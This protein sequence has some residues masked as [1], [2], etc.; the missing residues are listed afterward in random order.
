MFEKLI[1]GWIQVSFSSCCDLPVNDKERERSPGDR[2]QHQERVE[3][4]V[5]TDP[6]PVARNEAD[7]GIAGS[8]VA[9][10]QA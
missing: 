3:T 9:N 7:G 10:T 5:L 2:S 1:C 4:F 6:G 8:T